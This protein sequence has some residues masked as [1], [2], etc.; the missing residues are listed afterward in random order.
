MSNCYIIMLTARTD[1][2]VKLVG[3]S[4]GTDDHV[5]KPEYHR[6]A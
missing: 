5:T 4:M 2:L 3:L 1:E 6:A